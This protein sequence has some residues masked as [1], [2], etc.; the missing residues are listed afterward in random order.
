M[1]QPMIGNAVETL[2]GMTTDPLFG[3][4]VG[5]GLGGVQVGSSATWPFASRRSLIETPRT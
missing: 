4:L 3:P 1:I 5:F 2:I